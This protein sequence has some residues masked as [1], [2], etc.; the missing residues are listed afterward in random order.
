MT[1][2]SS[3]PKGV[4]VLG[5]A[6]EAIHAVRELAA[7]GHRVDWIPLEEME[8]PADLPPNGIMHTHGILLGFE[9]QAGE[10]IAQVRCGE[11]VERIS[12]GAVL[13]ALGNARY[14]PQARYGLP[15][16]PRVLTPSQVRKHLEE[17]SL[18]AILARR[19]AHLLVMLDLGGETCRETAVEALYLARDLRQ[20]HA[21]ITLFYRDLKVDSAPLERLTRAMRHEGIVFCRYDTASIHLDEEGVRIEAPDGPV[22]GDALI[23]P[24]AV[25]PHPATSELAALLKVRLGADGFFQEVNIRHYRPG[26]SN[27]KGIYFAGRCHMDA[28]LELALE[29]ASRGVASIDA[30]LHS[31]DEPPSGAFAEVDR[32]Q[33]IRCLTCVRT[34]PHRAAEMVEREGLLAAYIDARACWGCGI[35]V[36]HCPAQ[37]ISIKGEEMPSWLTAAP[38]GAYAR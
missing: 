18:A 17:R 33:C 30:F 34:C 28:D 2:P 12:A 14:Y 35:C 22:R 4:I 27:R 9:G 23:L 24:E 16:G 3:Q 7:L 29:D 37:A 19:S 8:R 36:A 32:G 6:P 25:Q 31:L 1:S 15:L 10:F 20:G 21:E 38:Q 11:A 26:L 13:I 5:A